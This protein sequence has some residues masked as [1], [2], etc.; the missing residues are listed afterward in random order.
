MALRRTLKNYG[1]ITKPYS[2]ELTI[3]KP[4]ITAYLTLLNS[5]LKSLFQ[6]F[7]FKN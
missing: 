6:V 4:E 2:T 1:S 5:L 7:L 3:F